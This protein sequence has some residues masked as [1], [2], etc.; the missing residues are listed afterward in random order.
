MFLC[1]DAVIKIPDL[2]V[3]QRSSSHNNGFSLLYAN[4]R[5]L[6]SISKSSVSSTL[7]SPAR[8]R[9]HRAI[10]RT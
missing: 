4:V 2:E 10:R 7:L 8:I 6:A 3:F 1:L 9:A 5:L